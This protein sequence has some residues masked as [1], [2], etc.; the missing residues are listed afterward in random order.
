MGNPGHA[1][2]SKKWERE[3]N[4]R[5]KSTYIRQYVREGLYQHWYDS[6]HLWEKGVYQRRQ[7]NGVW[8]TWRSDGKLRSMG[9][10]CVGHKHGIWKTWHFNEQ[11]HEQGEYH[12]GYKEGI[13]KTW[14]DTGQL[15]EECDYHRGHKYTGYIK[16]PYT[17]KQR[18]ARVKF[19]SMR[20]IR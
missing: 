12:M 6:G 15:K 19:Y 9:N 2:E 16:C 1:I 10:Y 14:D 11:L 13:W 20:F 18:Q 3:R 7:R 4:G 8:K 17:M 5:L